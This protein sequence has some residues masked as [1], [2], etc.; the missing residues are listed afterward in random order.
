MN[1]TEK[2]T[3]STTA[4]GRRRSRFV[5]S[6]EPPAMV[7]MARDL[8]LLELVARFRRLTASQIRA[9]VPFGSMQTASYR[10]Q[11]LWQHRFL[12]R[13]SWPVVEGSAPAVY[14]VAS[15][16]AGAL[17]AR[18]GGDARDFLSTAGSDDQVF[19]EHTLA[20]NDVLIAFELAAR[21]AG[22][23]LEWRRPGRPLDRPTDPLNDRQAVPL[24]PDATLNYLIGE[25]RL[26]AFLEVDRGT[27]TTARFCRK[28][29][30]YL[31]FW[32]SGTYG[33]Q[34]GLRA[35]RVLV[36]VPSRKRLASLAVAVET[37]V[38]VVAPRLDRM[39]AACLNMIW[40]A[41]QEQLRQDTV[42]GDPWEAGGKR[43]QFL[44]ESPSE[45]RNG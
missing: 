11:R 41:V 27:E 30:G 31:A 12:E 39:P 14:R 17:A 18:L 22:H 34:T 13:E 6:A 33:R 25:R 24:L 43:V 35:F 21:A 8:R 10:L 32:V 28:M 16:G 4:P 40:F 37:T 44:P 5:R 19:L 26:Q 7:L 15:R 45:V 36:V 2:P 20:L 23:R 3:H 38:K 1:E 29:R 9:V 42:L